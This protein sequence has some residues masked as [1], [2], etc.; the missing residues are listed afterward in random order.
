M[1]VDILDIEVIRTKVEHITLVVCLHVLGVTEGSIDRLTPAEQAL[2]VGS[3]IPQGRRG[4][5]L[6]MEILLVLSHY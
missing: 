4:C 2:K 3:L 1:H 5:L 6:L